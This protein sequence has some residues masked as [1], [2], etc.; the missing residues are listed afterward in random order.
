[1]QLGPVAL[2]MA[3]TLSPPAAGRFALLAIGVDADTIDGQRTVAEQLDRISYRE[4]IGK[5]GA[6]ETEAQAWARSANVGIHVRDAAVSL[7]VWCKMVKREQR[8]NPTSTVPGR[9]VAPGGSWRLYTRATCLSATRPTGS[10][11]RSC[12][13]SWRLASTWSNASPR[14]DL[15]EG[16][17]SEPRTRRDRAWRGSRARAW[18]TSRL[19]ARLSRRLRSHPHLDP[20][21]TPRGAHPLIAG[22]RS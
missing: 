17:A 9:H 7:R 2:A 19:R 11:S 15:G 14:S 4:S 10:T 16:G 12:Q 13:P 18:C 22:E 1:M 21:T 5:R 8:A 3:L 20:S 6:R